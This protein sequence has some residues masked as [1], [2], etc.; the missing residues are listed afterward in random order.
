M[1]KVIDDGL[2][3]GYKEL[4][5]FVDCVYCATLLFIFCDFSHHTT[6]N[7]SQRV[8]NT[9]TAI[10]LTTVDKITIREVCVKLR[11]SQS[12]NIFDLSSVLTILIFV[13]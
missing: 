11:L 8:Q 3:F 10:D 13:D 6:I 9:L 1:S 7:I 2:Q 12:I 4:G 5:L